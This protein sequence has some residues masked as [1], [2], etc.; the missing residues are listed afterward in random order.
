ME[1]IAVTQNKLVQKWADML[2]EIAEGDTVNYDAIK[3]KDVFEFF[4]LLRSYRTRL[5]KLNGKDTTGNRG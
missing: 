3:G 4:R 2:W 1:I 5:K